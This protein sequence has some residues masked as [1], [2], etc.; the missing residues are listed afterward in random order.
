[1]IKT[2]I[3]SLFPQK[4]SLHFQKS[5]S[6]FHGFTKWF[7]SVITLSSQ[8]VSVC[9]SIFLHNEKCIF[10]R[11]VSVIKFTSE[12]KRNRSYYLKLSVQFQRLVPLFL[13]FSHL[14]LHIRFSTPLLQL[15]AETCKN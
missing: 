8:K 14:N 13:Q 15:A 12:S 2:N 5:A 11:A 6:V 1:M 3:L 10:G 9:D 4:A 7:H